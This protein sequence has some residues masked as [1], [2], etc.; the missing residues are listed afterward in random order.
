M[1]EYFISTHG[2]RKGLADTA[3]QDG[4]FRLPDSPPGRR[5][6]GRHHQRIRLRHRR[7][8]LR[9]GHRGSRRN[10]RAAARPHRR[11]RVAEKI[12]DYDG[13]VV[14]DIDPG[15]HRRTRRSDSGRRHRAGEN[16]LSS[17]LR[18]QTRRLRDVLRPKPGVGPT[19]RTRRSHRCHCGAIHRR[20]RNPAHH[21]Y[22]PH[23]WYGIASLRAVA[24][25]CQE[26]R[27][28]PLYRTANG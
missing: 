5:G 6:A 11:P 22:L 25:G 23:R 18:I 27:T 8:H 12:K 17:Y 2:A 15:D 4:R 19:G 14:V 26:Q 7:R 20:T 9:V 21:A 13:N 16:P 28:G 1:L 10:Y 3:P 24:S